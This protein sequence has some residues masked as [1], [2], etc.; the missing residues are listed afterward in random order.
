M[1]F[2]YLITFNNAVISPKGF[3]HNDFKVFATIKGKLE[4]DAICSASRG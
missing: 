4:N 1:L 3:L 2:L